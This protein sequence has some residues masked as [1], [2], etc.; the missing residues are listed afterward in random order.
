MSKNPNASLSFL[1]WLRSGLG[2]LSTSSASARRETT[3]PVNIKDENDAIIGD[4]E[5]QR[6]TFTLKGP[7]DVLG[8]SPLMV[9]RT[10]PSAGANDHEP[11]YFPYLEFADPDLPWRYSLD[12][13]GKVKPWIVLIVLTRDEYDPI[14]DTDGENKRP[15]IVVQAKNGTLPLPDLA[16]SWAWSHVQLTGEVPENPEDPEDPEKIEK[17][18][19][20]NPE[21]CCSRLMCPRKLEP[22]TRYS[23]FVVPAYEVGR[24]AGLGE[25][26][27]EY[28]DDPAW[29]QNAERVTLP[30]YYRW[31][32][33]TSEAGDFEELLARI[34][35]G[36]VP[37]DEKKYYVGTRPIDGSRPGYFLD[38]DGN[39]KEYKGEIL[40]EG[41]LVPPNFMQED[42]KS[43]KPGEFTR[44]MCEELNRSLKEAPIHDQEDEDPLV[45]IPVYGRYFQKTEEIEMPNEE[46]KW[47]MPRSWVH[48]LNLDRRYRVAASFGT[49]VVQYNQEEYMQECWEQVGAIREA[50]EKIRLAAMGRIISD[51]LKE[52]HIDP[53]DDAR[54]TLITQPFHHYYAY[55]DGNGQKS[56]KAGFKRSGLPQGTVSYP[57]KRITIHRVGFDRTKLFGPWELA[58]K[59]KSLWRRLLRIILF[60]FRLMVQGAIVIIQQPEKFMRFV[61]GL[62][63][64][65]EKEIPEDDGTLLRKIVRIGLHIVKL[66]AKVALFLITNAKKLKKTLLPILYVLLYALRVPAPNEKP[67]LPDR[68]TRLGEALK[69]KFGISEEL[70][71]IYPLKSEVIRV[72]PI[73]VKKSLRPCLNM[74]ADLLERLN[75]TIKVPVPGGEQQLTSFDPIMKAP[76]IDMPMYRHLSERSVDLMVPGLKL[77]EHNT[78]T[79]FQENRKNIEAYLLQINGEMGR[80]L[81][82][83]EFPTDQ[84]GTIFKYFWDPT[85]SIDAPTDIRDIHEWSGELGTHPGGEDGAKE[86]RLVLAIKADLI[87]RYPNT[88]IFAIKKKEDKE[89]ENIFKK[90]DADDPS[91]EDGI[92]HLVNGQS[93]AQD[94]SFF[95]YP[96]VFS[97]NIGVDV[98]FL[99]FPFSI[100][101]ME[102][103]KQ[104]DYGYYFIIMEHP[105]LP[106]FGLDVKSN[107]IENPITDWDKMSWGHAD[108]DAA[109][110]WVDAEE[111]K[112]GV[113]VEISDGGPSAWD[114]HAAGKA[115]ITYQKPV[116]IVVPSKCFLEKDNKE[117]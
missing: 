71:H 107:Q 67:R 24:K 47:S 18:I 2:A 5:Q 59:N 69:E 77:L 34:S 79:L 117:K 91:G 80:E 70:D 14:T 9:A 44:D 82:W 81:V 25:P 93:H 73:D 17:Y 11:N 45:P 41:A 30:A 97:A 4:P 55:D 84:R 109:S 37:Q 65:I 10:E 22:N 86:N 21:L 87:R 42:R 16:Q 104:D 50:N 26:I 53:L 31:D 62:R 98:L 56:F 103:D 88:I 85:T 36:P 112:E 83:R 15:A 43:F 113:T 52:R 72:T 40:L 78:S 1:P 75:S 54:F 49:S 39:E 110:G 92:I 29:Y 108:I 23:A 96:P 111:L 64:F 101:N 51:N 38:A 106:R 13:D 114:C 99:G 32:F 90:L 35:Y 20:N 102:R 58:A 8:Y 48:E 46:G 19:I 33:Q 76:Q 6:F 105:S 3:I 27:D 60:I 63:N 7:G 12:E 66:L 57:F 94:N 100:E 89:W 61:P 115:W 28:T 95:V 74:R 68:D 116:R